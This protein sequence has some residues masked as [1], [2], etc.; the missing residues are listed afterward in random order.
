MT[1]LQ[2]RMTR[3][4]ERVEE[5]FA[6]LEDKISGAEERLFWKFSAVDG[7]F[8]AFEEKMNSRFHSM[9]MWNVAGHGLVAGSIIAAIKL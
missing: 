7:R 1:R 2:D 6:H 5:R 8:L 4:E 3:F 9:M